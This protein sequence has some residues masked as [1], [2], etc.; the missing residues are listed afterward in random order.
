MFGHNWRWFG[1]RHALAQEHSPHPLSPRKRNHLLASVL[2]LSGVLALGSVLMWLAFEPQPLSPPVLA[3]IARPA[4][5]LIETSYTG[6]LTVPDFNLSGKGAQLAESLFSSEQ[7]SAAALNLYRAIAEHPLELLAPSGGGRRA[8]HGGMQGSGFI[9]TPDGY[10]VTNARTVKLEYTLKERPAA[11]TAVRAAN[12][13]NAD[14]QQQYHAPLPMPLYRALVDAFF[15]FYTEQITVDLREVHYYAVMGPAAPGYAA[16]RSGLPCTLVTTGIPL[17]GKDVAILKMDGV[18]LPT[19][20]MGNDAALDITDHLFILGYP[21]VSTFHPLMNKG[22]SA[23]PPVLTSGMVSTRRK[24]NGGWTA[25]QT[26]AAITRGTSGAPALDSTGHVIGLATF[27]TIDPTIEAGDSGLVYIVPASI[28][29]DFLNQGNVRLTPGSFTDLYSKALV[30]FNKQHYRTALGYLQQLKP[31]APV[32]PYL[33]D[34]LAE[35]QR[36][37]TLG[38]D[39]SYEDTLHT[40]LDIAGAV[41][42]LGLGL[43]GYAWVRRHRQQCEPAPP[44]VLPLHHGGEHPA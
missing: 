8:I 41:L 1:H 5:V 32:N 33:R 23:M 3:E 2:G 4:T 43:A 24:M 17:P 28:I 22:M 39:R 26:D 6:T 29:M 21:A 9:V 36:E 40:A 38:H 14:F 42:L 37:I 31:L 27:G 18:N 44:L 11:Q 16:I 34:Y 10:V 19:L 13:L 25:I 12:T 7:P 20:P 35:A 30:Q 15:A